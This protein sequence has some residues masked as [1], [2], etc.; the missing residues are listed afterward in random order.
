MSF[1]MANAC[2]RAREEQLFKIRERDVSRSSDNTCGCRGM[3]AE[4]RNPPGAHTESAPPLTCKRL[5]H[6]IRTI[7]KASL[8]TYPVL[9]IHRQTG[10]MNNEDRMN[11]PSSSDHCLHIRDGLVG[12]LL[13]SDNPSR[14]TCPGIIR[15]YH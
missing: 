7:Q 6:L 15:W 11:T 14:R 9:S 5:R 13:S 10:T 1:L 12:Y 2:V 3:R 4:G 8:I